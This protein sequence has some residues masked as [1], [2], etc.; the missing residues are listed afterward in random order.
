MAKIPVAVFLLIL[1][2][3]PMFL[4]VRFRKRFEETIFLSAGGIVAILFLFG[5]IGILDIG[6]YA[7][8]AAAAVLISLSAFFLV[9]KPDIEVVKAFFTPAFAAFCL[10][11]LFLLYAN[12]GRM[13]SDWDEFTHWGDTVRAMTTTG[14]LSTSPLNHAQFPSYVPG[15][16]LLQYLLEKILMGFNGGMFIDGGLYFAF[17][18]M[19]FITILPFFTEKRWKLF[20]PT[21]LV[22]LC[23]AVIPCFL[24]ADYL[25][26]IY[27]DSYVGVLAGAGFAYLFLKEKTWVTHVHILTACFLLVLAKDV[28]LLFAIGIA[29]AWM[30]QRLGEGKTRK[31]KILAAGIAV[32]VVA[33]PKILWEISIT[34]NGVTARFRD[35]VDIG[36]LWSVI[37]GREQGT[38]HDIFFGFFRKWFTS[39]VPLRGETGI[40]VLYP[41]MGIL[42]IALLAWLKWILNRADPGQRKQRNIAFAAMIALFVI[43]ILGMPVIYMFRFAESA[44]V[45]FASF[46][47]Y[48]SMIYGCL[49]TAGLLLA[50]VRMQEKPGAFVWGFLC[51]LVFTFLAVPPENFKSYVSRESVENSG[52]IQGQYAEISDKILEITGGE[53]KKVW[54]IVQASDGHE[55][56]AIRY[57]IRPCIGVTDIGS[58]IAANTNSLYSGDRWTKQISAE[59]WKNRLADFDYVLIYKVNDTFIGDY[60]S[61]FAKPE[62]I[63]SGTIFGVNHDTGLLELA[64]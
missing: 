38:M 45:K 12:S 11:C 31:E 28:G 35:P 25:T 51:I 34:A 56:W 40:S 52:Y 63:A 60:A 48:L 62:D 43:Y 22:F 54:I 2:S 59:E 7:V 27:I 33:L 5:L 9:R 50:T 49:L 53:A 23:I 64:D 20:I 10:V 36:V 61:V 17:Q 6:V 57:L 47:R 55:F 58:S 24:Q 1:V 15:M 37:T 4:S 30:F 13:V 44:A 14:Q 41:L 26:S 39:A 18:V 3:L 29:T 21:L 42:L 46:D 8:A 16:A 32:A 19:A